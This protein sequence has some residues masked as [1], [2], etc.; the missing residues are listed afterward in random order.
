M[1][2]S[3]LIITNTERYSVGIAVLDQFICA[4]DISMTH[5]PDVDIQINSVVK[6]LPEPACVDIAYIESLLMISCLRPESSPKP[7]SSTL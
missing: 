3:N 6:L 4:T 7:N 5:C 1:E 2:I